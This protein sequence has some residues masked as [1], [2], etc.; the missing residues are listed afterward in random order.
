MPAR[1]LP[2][3]GRASASQ[4]P[5]K[6][7]PS[8]FLPPPAPRGLLQPLWGPPHIPPIHRQSFQ[9]RPDIAAQAARGR[10]QTRPLAAP[11]S[12]APGPNS[13]L[14]GVAGP[15][16]IHDLLTCSSPSS[17]RSQ[18]PCPGGPSP[19]GP[20]GPLALSPEVGKA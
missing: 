2:G 4:R 3:H 5:G 10:S 17:G 7:P 9:L 8:C 6:A 16:V 14:P 13:P 1:P 11:A 18:A 12:S 20:C 19:R 15:A